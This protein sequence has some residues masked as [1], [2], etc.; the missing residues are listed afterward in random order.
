MAS[1]VKME[2]ITRSQYQ[3]SHVK[4]QPIVSDHVYEI[5]MRTQQEYWNNKRTIICVKHPQKVILGHQ[6]ALYLG[7][8]DLIIINY[9]TRKTCTKH[10]PNQNMFLVMSMYLYVYV[11]FNMQK[12][13]LL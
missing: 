13:Y 3:H 1:Q 2:V 9:N 11:D 12:L 10:R 7:D 5:C 8:N 6:G 4:P